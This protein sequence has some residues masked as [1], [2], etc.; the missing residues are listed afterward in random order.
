VLEEITGIGA[1]VVVP[2]FLLACVETGY[3]FVTTILEDRIAGTR[4]RQRDGRE[5]VTAGEVAA[6]FAGGVFPTFVRDR[7]RGDASRDAKGMEKPLDGERVQV[8]RV[9]LFLLLKDASTQPD[10]SKWK[11]LKPG[12]GVSNFIAR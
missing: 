10:R 7:A 9:G 8:A 2:Y 12:T 11:R 3:Q 1:Q 6:E 5:I 4:G